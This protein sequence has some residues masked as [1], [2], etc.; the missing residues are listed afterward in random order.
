MQRRASTRTS[1]I[2][3]LC[4][5]T[6]M[7]EAGAGNG[8][9]EKT[10]QKSVFVYDC[11]PDSS[12]AARTISVANTDYDAFLQAVR[13]VR[14]SVCL[15]VC[16]FTVFNRPISRLNR[17]VTLTLFLWSQEFSL[18]KNESFVI[19]TT[20]RRQIDKDLYSKTSLYLYSTNHI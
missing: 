17:G 9:R 20:D 13:R 11:R 16:L 2:A 12:A 8:D 7:A 18:S 3:P 19:S 4:I 5:D 1:H 6:N 10:P 14:A 15:F